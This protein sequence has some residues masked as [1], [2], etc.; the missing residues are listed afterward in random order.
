[1]AIIKK[2]RS[3]ILSV[4]ACAII[5]IIVLNP[6]LDYDS[7]PMM[8]YNLGFFLPLK[9]VAGIS[10]ICALAIGIERIYK[11]ENLI[12]NIVSAIIATPILINVAIIFISLFTFDNE[13]PKPEHWQ[14]KPVFLKSDTIIL[15]SNDTIH[16]VAYNWGRDL[17]RRELYFT[18]TPYLSDTFDINEA[19]CYKG[20]DSLE[21]SF[22]TNHDTLLVYITK[23]HACYKSY[24]AEYVDR[25][26]LKRVLV[27]QDKLDSLKNYDHSI[28]QFEW[29]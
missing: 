15:E 2:Y 27:S 7:G 25:I 18:Q 5:T 24:K 20:N 29:K 13:T 17:T 16:L 14:I 21:V 23:S 3:L 12:V 11:R 4:I 22:K 1:M 19:Y 9:F 28:N 8:A 10:S 26:P 6:P